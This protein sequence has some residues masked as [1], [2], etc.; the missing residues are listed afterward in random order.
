MI[1]NK[2]SHQSVTFYK[3]GL[4]S[5][6]TRDAVTAAIDSGILVIAAAGNQRSMLA[7]KY[8]AKNGICL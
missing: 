7:S 5:Q 1:V 2:G 6:V 3:R 4:Q 8:I